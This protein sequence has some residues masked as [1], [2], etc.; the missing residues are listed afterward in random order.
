MRRAETQDRAGT[1]RKKAYRALGRSL[2]A[3]PDDLT[4]EIVGEAME[5]YLMA[6]LGWERSALTRAA[7][8]LHLM[9]RD[10]KLAASWDELWEACELQRYGATAANTSDMAQRILAL[11][12]TTEA[13]WS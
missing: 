6:K 5:Q 3:K 12:Q 2:R 4:P 1:R 10:P 9:E 13:S 11:A 8:Y 7:V